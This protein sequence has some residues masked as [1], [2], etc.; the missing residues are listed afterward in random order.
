MREHAVVADPRTGQKDIR[1]LEGGALCHGPVLAVGNR[2]LASGSRGHRPVVLS[3]RLDMRGRPRVFAAGDQ[4]VPSGSPGRLW[5][6]RTESSRGELAFASLREVSASGRTVYRVRR[7]LP[8]WSALRAAVAGGLIFTRRS[9]LEWWHPRT[10]RVVRR[11]PDAWVIAAGR[12]R[13]ASCRERCGA[14]RVST[15]TSDRVLRP[16][17]GVRLPGTSGAFS[18]DGARLAVPVMREGIWQVAVVDLET[19]RWNLVPRARLSGYRS[20][21]W[22]LSGEWLY[23]TGR[24][25][26]ILAWRQGSGRPLR[27]PV[28]PGGTVVSIATAPASG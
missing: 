14:L 24:G 28:R 10:G 20:I 18:P 27:L 9:A 16:P 26:R 13:L 4:V 12:T 2:V 15:A 25:S 22:S 3:F 19:G 7:R 23:F 21:A 5:V 6:A 17:A 1:Q 11:L 8:P